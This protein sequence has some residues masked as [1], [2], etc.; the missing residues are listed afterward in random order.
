MKMSTE[1]CCNNTDIGKP[2]Y[3]VR[4]QSIAALSTTI[5]T[6]VRLELDPVLRCKTLEINHKSY[7]K[8]AL[9]ANNI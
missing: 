4:E 3:M 6:R 8:P 5:L 2:K 9:H 1:L 7:L